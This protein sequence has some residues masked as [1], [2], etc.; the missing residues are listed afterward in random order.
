MI[1]IAIRNLKLFFRD[2]SGVVMSFLAVFVILGLYVLFL[3][4]T[5]TGGFRDMPG[6]RFLI[7]NWIIS[8]IL[9]VISMTTTLGAL[10]IMVE[11]KTKK[12]LRDFYS[13]PIKRYKLA[14]GYILSTFTVGVILSVVTLT[15]TEVYFAFT[16]CELLTVINMLKVVGVIFLSVFV[17]SSMMF[18][19]VSF[20]ESQTA[21]STGSTVIGT[22]IGF[23]TGVYIPIGNF[24][25][26]VQFIIKIFPVSHAGTLF[27]QI[28][29]ERPIA[30]TFAN[31]PQEVIDT[32]KKNMGIVF[33]FNGFVIN[34]TASVIILIATAI[35]FYG[36]AIIRLY[37]KTKGK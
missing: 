29:L 27:R 26:P 23:L 16:G 7:D 19:L 35:L 8:G 9:A 4:D 6:I 14:G 33:D 21:Y 25:E 31:A 37:V 36:L 3:G 15:V 11:D 12:I 18:F 17:S 28:I 1:T 34:E 10:G 5:M 32:F 24:P 30:V 2:K 22:L 13:S 20:F